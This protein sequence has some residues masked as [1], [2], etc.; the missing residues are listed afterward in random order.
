[1]LMQKEKLSWNNFEKIWGLSCESFISVGA[2]GID[3][4]RKVY[5]CVSLAKNKP[6][7]LS[8]NLSL[9]EGEDSA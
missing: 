3:A 1:M 7:V 5:S 8:R 4:A 6:V 9:R 2:F